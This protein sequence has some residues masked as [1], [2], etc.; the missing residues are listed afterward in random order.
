MNPSNLLSIVSMHLKFVLK[1]IRI[2][3]F[4]A[5]VFKVA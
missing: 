5:V 4:I 2:L 1:S 3:M